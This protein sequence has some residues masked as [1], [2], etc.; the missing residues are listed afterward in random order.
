MR[1]LKFT[2]KLD[3]DWVFPVTWLDR[4]GD[5]QQL[6]GWQ[7]KKAFWRSLNSDAVI[8]TD[9]D[10]A[11]ALDEDAFNPDT[12]GDFTYRRAADNQTQFAVGTYRLDFEATLGL[13]IVAVPEDNYVIVEVKA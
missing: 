6:T 9:T 7:T 3:T 2:R 13:E 5:R 1:A 10:A 12:F 11:F 4:N 8:V